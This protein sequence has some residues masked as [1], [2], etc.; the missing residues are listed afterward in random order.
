MLHVYKGKNTKTKNNE[1]QLSIKDIIPSYCTLSNK[2]NIAELMIL[3]K[4]GLS[5]L[6]NKLSLLSNKKLISPLSQNGEIIK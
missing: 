3:F 1:I 5:R 6:I 4:I 2:N